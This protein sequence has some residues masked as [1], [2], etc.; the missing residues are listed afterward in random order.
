MNTAV[1]WTEDDYRRFV[2]R[3]RRAADR[4]EGVIETAVI[5]LAPAKPA[6]YRNKTEAAYAAELE[7]VRLAG[8]IIEWGYEDAKLRLANGAWFTPDFRVVTVA[9]ATEFHEV[10]GFWRE[11]ARVRIKVAA[12]RF[13]RYRFIALTKRKAR[14]GGGWA[15]E[16]FA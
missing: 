4:I 16:V 5:A 6:R 8:A 9:G 12:D 10:K 2:A 11:A 3:T 1:R 13:P 7:Q 14:D 15:R